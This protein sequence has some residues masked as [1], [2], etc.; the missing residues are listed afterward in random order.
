MTA[1]KHS[2]AAIAAMVAAFNPMAE[3]L[4]PM[5]VQAKH[6]KPMTDDEIADRKA[7]RKREKQA[8]RRQR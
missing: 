1:P 7:R 4:H 5:K 2:F 8:R 6:S 3:P